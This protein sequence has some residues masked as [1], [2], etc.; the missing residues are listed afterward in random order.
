[1]LLCMTSKLLNSG[2]MLNLVYNKNDYS[3]FFDVSKT[4]NYIK[5]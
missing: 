5:L 3:S 1:M 4:V 2:F